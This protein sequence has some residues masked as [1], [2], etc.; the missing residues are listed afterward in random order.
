[1]CK[2]IIVICALSRFFLYFSNFCS[3]VNVQYWSHT[4]ISTF[5]QLCELAYIDFSSKQNIFLRS[6][7][8]GLFENKFV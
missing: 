8:K 7:V 5:N 6:A 2:T 4:L 3:D 1:M